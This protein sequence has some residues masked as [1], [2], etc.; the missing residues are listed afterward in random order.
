MPILRPVSCVLDVWDLS[1]EE[2]AVAVFDHGVSPYSQFG[3]VS[4]YLLKR[5]IFGP[6]FNLGVQGAEALGRR[7]GVWLAFS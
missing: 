2:A 5:F 4:L 7:F 6:N 3:Q 1:G